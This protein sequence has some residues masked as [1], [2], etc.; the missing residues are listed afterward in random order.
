MPKVIKVEQFFLILSGQLHLRVCIDDLVDHAINI[1]KVIHF[2]FIPYVDLCLI[3]F[4]CC[5]D[6]F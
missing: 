2:L 4:Q 6:I 1:K 5:S 3:V